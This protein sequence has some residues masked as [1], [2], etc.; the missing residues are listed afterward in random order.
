MIA[1]L[2]GIEPELVR[3]GLPVVLG[4]EDVTPEWTLLSFHARRELASD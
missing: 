2:K 1:T 3:I 4:Y